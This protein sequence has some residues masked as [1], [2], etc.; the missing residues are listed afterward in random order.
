MTVINRNDCAELDRR[1]PL[2]PLR[3]EFL[4]PEGI[5]YLDG[6][7]L[8]PLP[9]AAVEKLEQVVCDE[10]GQGL[11]RSWNAAG[12][13]AAPQR[14]GDRLAP[15]IGAEPGEVVVADSTS[16]NLFKLLVG[17]LKMKPGRRV[18]LTETDNFPTDL[19]IAQGV[20]EVFDPGY[21]LRLVDAGGIAKALDEDVAVVMLTHVN[22]KSGRIHDMDTITRAAH[23]WGALVLW[24]L[25][26]SAGALTLDLD[27]A[28]ADFAVGCGYKFLNGGPGAPAFLY[29]ARRL[30]AE[31]RP[32]LTGWMGHA[33]PFAFA[34]HYVPAEGIRRNLCG[35]PAILGMAALDAAL[36]VWERVD[37]AEVRRKS[38]R[39]GDLFIRL[40]EDRCT[41]C[42]FRLAAPRDGTERGSQ[43][44]FRHH[45]GFPI[46]QALI[47][48]GVIG[49]FRAPDLLRFGLA[50]L[51]LRYVD[52]WDAVDALAEMMASGAWDRPEFKRRAFVT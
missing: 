29:V 16:V 48:R 6:N 43:V 35:T 18:I 2:A 28:G 31:L 15:L 12:W 26:H 46:M 17:A 50:P 7:S 30:Q 9:K 11:V 22:F 14:L 19:Y 49:D 52:V 47:A 44:S 27:R 42:G 23:G 1:D 32:V 45:D 13:I 3:H 24:D 34:P 8:G 5:I 40:V 39:M 38:I 33:Q 21:E 25:A 51:Y 4:L 10:W 37:L 41:G 36:D 20:I